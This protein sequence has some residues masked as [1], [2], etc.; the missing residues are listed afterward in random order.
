[1]D[2]IKHYAGEVR[3]YTNATIPS[4][5]LSC[6]GSVLNIGDY[7]ALA[8]VLGTTFGGDGITTFGLPDLRDVAVIGDG[9]GAGL[10]LRNYGDTGGELNHVLT[11]DEL[12]SHNHDVNVVSNNITG[13]TQSATDRVLGVSSIGSPGSF[14]YKQPPSTLDLNLYNGGGSSTITFTNSISISHANTQPSLIL[15]FIIA[16]ETIRDITLTDGVTASDDTSLGLEITDGV[17][18]SDD[19]EF[20]LEIT[21]GVTTSDDKEFGL[22]ITD[23]ITASDSEQVEITLEI[24]DGVTISDDKELGLE[25]TDGVTTSD[26]KEFGLEIVD[27]VTISDDKELGLEITDGITASDDKEFG[28]EIVDIIKVT[29]TNVSTELPGHLFEVY[30]QADNGAVDL[31]INLVEADQ[32]PVLVFAIL[33]SDNSPY[34]L[35]G[36]TITLLVRERDALPG[37]FKI[38]QPMEILPSGYVRYELQPTDTD[39]P[40][41]YYA[42]I[43]ISFGGI[44]MTTQQ[45]LIRI[46]EQ[47]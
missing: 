8:S 29:D 34:N 6:D 32:L 4:G 38:N 23:G 22:E 47:L 41:E 14:L 35:T 42:E 28:L 15:R 37:D 26:D 36:A 40:G 18:T 46:R 39:T 9:A 10:T 19:K 1:M 30:S 16:T 44:L 45:F 31:V 7:P 13:F 17:T 11:V 43:E 25:I 33:D 5:W 3:I 20:G 21:D 12:P 27:G 24:T 2:I